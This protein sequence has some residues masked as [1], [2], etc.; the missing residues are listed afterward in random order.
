MYVDSDLLPVNPGHAVALLEDDVVVVRPPVG[1]TI[2]MPSDALGDALQLVRPTG[3]TGGR[4]RSRAHSLHR[5]R[6]VAGVLCAGRSHPRAVRR[7]QGA[8]AHERAARAVRQQLPTARPINLLQGRY[9]PQSTRPVGWQAWRIAAMLLVGL[10]VLHAVG[11]GAELFMLKRAEQKVDANLQEAF[12]A[13]MPGEQSTTNARH[14]M[15]ASSSPR[16]TAA[17]AA[18]FRRLQR[19]STREIPFRYNRAGN[20]LSGWGPRV[21]DGCTRCR[22]SRSREPAPANQRLGRQSHR[23]QRGWAK[24][25]GT[26]PDSSEGHIVKFSLDTMNERERRM[27]TIGGVAAALLVIFG[28]VL[29][30]DSSVSKAQN[31]NRA[32]AGGSRVDAVCGPGAG[33]FRPRRREA[34][35]AG[36][37]SRR[38]RSRGPRGGSWQF[39][40]QQRA[41]WAGPVARAAGESAVRHHDRLAGTTRGAERHRRR[42]GVGRQCGRPGPSSTRGLVL[43]IK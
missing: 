9:T 41:G 40:H 1:A 22:Q 13:A 18:C 20:E 4:Q 34:L 16:A 37:A 11:K 21:E 26:N 10:V 3:E 24:L 2:T 38:G 35:D 15:E 12:K 36:V 25:R 42:V 23:R 7:H 31:A 8:V 39:A 14:R 43:Q 33:L 19:W 17:A 6:R 27:V 32:E 30:L 28:I 29:P 5:R